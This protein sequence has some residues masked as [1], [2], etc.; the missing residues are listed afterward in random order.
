MSPGVGTL[1]AA[2][3]MMN[4]TRSGGISIGRTVAISP[5]QSADQDDEPPS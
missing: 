2:V 4:M 5:Q 1:V 3:V